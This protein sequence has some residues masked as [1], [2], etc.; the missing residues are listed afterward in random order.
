MNH[1]FHMVDALA[2]LVRQLH[3][4][5]GS[6]TYKLDT[7]FFFITSAYKIQFH[8]ENKQGGRKSKLSLEC[9][10]VSFYTLVRKVIYLSTQI[11]LQIQI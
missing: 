6:F 10:N 5:N 1:L 4:T 9:L 3:E 2:S 11:S 7:L 8:S